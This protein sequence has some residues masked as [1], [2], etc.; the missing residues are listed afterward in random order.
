[1]RPFP[2]LIAFLALFETSLAIPTA[3]TATT[4]HL[5]EKRAEGSGWQ[6]QSR[7]VGDVTLP[8]RIG[9]RQSNLENADKYLWEVSNP[10]STKFGTSCGPSFV[11]EKIP[12]V[13]HA[14][15]KH[16][17]A[18]EVAKAFAPTKDTLD[19]VMGWLNESGISRERITVSTGLLAPISII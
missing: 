1:M 14:A 19:Q 2:V 17:T 10:K 18:D 15:G 8:L 7:A 12:D 6:K 3:N 16:W 11:L 4:Y 5:H 13:C 9:L